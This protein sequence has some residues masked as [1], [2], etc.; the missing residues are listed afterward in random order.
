MAHMMQFDTNELPFEISIMLHSQNLAKS[1]R[2]T[3]SRYFVI[4]FRN[5][6]QNLH[7]FVV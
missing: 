4:L 6:E 2:C 3:A 5:F 1:L 7:G